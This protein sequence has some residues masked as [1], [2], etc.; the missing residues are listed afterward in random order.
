MNFKFNRLRKVCSHDFRLN[1][2]K[3]FNKT[4]FSMK[5]EKEIEF[6]ELIIQNRFKNRCEIIVATC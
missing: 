1:T 6:F 3:N 5:H 4:F 2:L